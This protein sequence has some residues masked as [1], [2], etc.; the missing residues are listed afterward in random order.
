MTFHTWQEVNLFYPKRTAGGTNLGIQLHVYLEG[1]MSNQIVRDV[2]KESCHLH[3]NGPES[4][5][6]LET[7]VSS[8]RG[9]HDSG[10]HLK[11]NAIHSV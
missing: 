6:V 8:V 4:L 5:Q 9:L 2:K 11:S 1:V 3:K 7:M 10:L